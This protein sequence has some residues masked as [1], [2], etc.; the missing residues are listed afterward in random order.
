MAWFVHLLV[1]VWILSAPVT[2][3][4]A[5]YT[6]VLHTHLNALTQRYLPTIIRLEYAYNNLIL[7]G[8]FVMA[9]ITWD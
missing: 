6:V 2:K 4:Q 3:L 7:K 9:A 1:M 8:V 5:L